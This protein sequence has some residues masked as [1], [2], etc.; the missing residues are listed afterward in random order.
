MMSERKPF[1]SS[2]LAPAKAAANSLVCV[3]FA[4]LVAPAAWGQDQP[5]SQ[6]RTVSIPISIYTQQELRTG[7]Q[8]ELVEVDQLIV[9]ENGVE[10]TILSIRSIDEAPLALAVL[11]QDDLTSEFNLQLKDIANFIR[12]LPKGSRVMVGYLRAGVLQV[13]QRFTTDLEKAARSLRVV[14]SSTTVSPRNPYDGVLDALNRFDSLP[15]G[16]RAIFMVSDGVD[17]SQGFFGATPSQSVDLDRAI[18]NA[19]RKSVSV[20]SI[21]S[22]TVLTDNRNTTLALFGQGS[23]E[24]LAKETG[25]RAF[26]QGQIAPI[27]YDPFFR[28]LK[29]LLDRQFLLTYLS[30]STKKGFYRL[31]VLSTNPDVRIVHPK[32][33]VYR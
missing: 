6:A 2:R 32:G 30:T 24:R 14:G 33:Y 25:G 22:P 9:R 8:Q 15:A 7:Q 23:L 20:F 11:I 5:N 3:L 26:F 29:L 21:Y 10:Q 16:R 31:D 13:R 18:F 12:G 17:A 28:E 19:Q 27:S 4:L 1:R